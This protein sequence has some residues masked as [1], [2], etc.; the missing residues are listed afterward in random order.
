MIK[1]IDIKWKL[2]E[3]ESIIQFEIQTNNIELTKLYQKILTKTYFKSLGLTLIS[4]NQEKKGGNNKDQSTPHVIYDWFNNIFNSRFF[5][6]HIPQNKRTEHEPDPE[7]D[8][9][10]EDEHEEEEHDDEPDPE[11][12]NE[13]EDEHE[14]EDEQEQEDEHEEDEHEEEQEDEQEEEQEEE[15][16]DEQEDEHEEEDETVYKFEIVGNLVLTETEFMD[17]KRLSKKETDIEKDSN[18]FK[19]QETLQIDEETQKQRSFKKTVLSEEEKKLVESV[20]Y[21]K[22]PIYFIKVFEKGKEN[23]DNFVSFKRLS[24]A[25]LDM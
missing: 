2:L 7:T 16:E 17:Y 12:D 9:E 25:L 10:Q 3:Q 23:D 11:T 22:I 6:F 5:Q 14:E 1:P 24:L 15:Q 19:R 8:N 21:N 13:Q 20:K 18:G 4:N